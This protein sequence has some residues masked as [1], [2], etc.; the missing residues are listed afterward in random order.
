MLERVHLAKNVA[1]N[2]CDD[3]KNK[4][5]EGKDQIKRLLMEKRNIEGDTNSSGRKRQ[6]TSASI[7]VD[8]LE[9][10]IDTKVNINL[11]KKKYTSLKVIK[12]KAIEE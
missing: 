11:L 4:V 12:E 5:N 9:K 1:E 2:K 10:N 7:N 3:A 6:L 8:N